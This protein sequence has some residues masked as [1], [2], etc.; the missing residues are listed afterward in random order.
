MDND[1]KYFGRAIEILFQSNER[2]FRK[3]LYK[4]ASIAP[5]ALVEAVDGPEK[6]AMRFDAAKEVEPVISSDNGIG[7]SSVVDVVENVTAEQ[8]K[9]VPQ[10]SDARNTDIV[11]VLYR[12]GYTT[13]QI[14]KAANVNPT[15]VY[16]WKHKTRRPNALRTNMLMNLAIEAGVSY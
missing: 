7:V 9:E 2:N 4:V 6:T 13:A 1:T 14:A 11:D 8:K 10:R 12:S 16:K 3:I 15:T 5:W